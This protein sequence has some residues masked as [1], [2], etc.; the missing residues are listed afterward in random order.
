MVHCVIDWSEFCVDDNISDEDEV[1]A[2]HG[3][4]N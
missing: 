3:D 2:D 4:E 1:D